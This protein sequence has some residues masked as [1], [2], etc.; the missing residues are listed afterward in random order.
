MYDSLAGLSVGDAFG[1][2]F[3]WHIEDIPAR[4]VDVPEWRWTDDTEMALSIVS[5]LTRYG[6]ID[7]NE[8]ARAFAARFDPRRGYGA[9]MLFEL[10]PKLRNGDDWR[11][12]ARALFDGSGSYGNGAAMRVAPLGAYF[13]DDLGTVIDEARRSAEVTHAHHEGV[14][15]AITVAVAAALAARQRT[16]R[17]ISGSRTFIEAVLPHVPH[18][19]VRERLS[20]LRQQLGPHA[21][22]EKV[23]QLV[24][25]GSQVSAQ[26]TVPLCLWVAGRH[27]NNYEEALWETVSVQGDM[28]T[29]CAIVGGIVAAHVGL[30]GIPAEWIN[31]REPLPEGVV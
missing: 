19:I 4:R 9:A 18:S 29:N 13:A 21:S 2:Q 17:T 28:D 1:E 7:Q 23:A 27:L 5:I 26:D 15:G 11:A 8:L 25:N 10:L 14:A 6:T 3:L 30:D 12:A 20:A 22:I 16:G 31:S 24:G